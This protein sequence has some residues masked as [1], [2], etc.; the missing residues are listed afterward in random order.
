MEERQKTTTNAG[1]EKKELR[2]TQEWERRS[3]LS[4]GNNR[5]VETKGGQ[6]MGNDRMP[7]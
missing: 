6:S 3:E 7:A 1:S 2:E 4:P 5:A